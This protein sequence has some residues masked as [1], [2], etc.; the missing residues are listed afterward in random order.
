MSRVT[1]VA[2]LLFGS[3]ACSLVYETV[4]LREL[5]L[6]FGASTT[7]S[8][9][10]VAC[11]VGGLGAGGLIFGK[12]ADAHARPLALYARL[13][14]GIA[15]TAAVTPLLLVV[16]RAAYLGMGGTMTLGGF[17]GSVVR[18]LLA[19]M[20]FAVPTILMG[21]TLPAV[22]RAIESG[23]DSGRRDVAMLY[24]VNTL[25][26][27]TGCLASTFVLFEVLGTRLTLWCA[28]LVN[29]L[30]AVTANA[31]ARSMPARAADEG[32][33]DAAP[34]DAGPRP[35]PSPFVL[36]AAAIA[37]FVFCVMELVWYRM[38]GPLLGGT[39]FTFGLI[40]A[41]ALGGIGLGGVAYGA[42]P[43]SRAAT[44]LGFALTCLLEAAFVAI[45][46]A[47]G[48]RL[49]VLAAVLRPLGGLS[50][51]LQVTSW[52][53][54]TAI[55]VL[56]AAFVSGV[57]FPLLIGLLGRGDQAVGRDVGRA[58][59][60]NTLG[61]IAG[62]LAGGFG[63]MPA[64]SAPGCWRLVVWM[65]LLLGGAA[66][67][68]DVRR[69]P[70]AAVAPILAGVAALLCLR[71]QGPTA[72]W[73]HSPIGAGRVD[74]SE[75]RT[76]NDV[77]AW[78]NRR[79]RAIEWE[80][81]GRESSVA[82]SDEVG[83]AFIINGK[84]DG[85]VRTDASTAVMAGMVGAMLHPNP[86]SAMV[87]GLGTGE[88]AG[89]LAAIDSVERVDV[90]ELEP[91]VREVARRSAAGNHGALDNAKV[92]ITIGDARELL[93]TSKG[94]YDLIASEPSNPYR[95]GIAS[96]FTQSY[97]EAAR[98]RLQDGGLFLQWLQGYEVEAQTVRTVYATLASVFPEVETWEL[99]GGDM[100][101]VASGRP[102]E[103]D[104]ARMRARLAREPYKS[105]LALTWRAIDVEGF[106]SHFVAASALARQVADAE[107]EGINTDDRNIVEFGF[108]RSV[109]SGL[110]HFALSEVRRAARIRAEH[111]P[112]LADGAV[113]WERVDDGVGSFYLS[114]SLDPIEVGEP[115]PERQHRM[116]ALRDWIAGDSRRAVSEWR[117][118]PREAIDPT[119]LVVVASALADTGDEGALAYCDS[120]RAWEPGEAD[121]I[122]ASFRLRQGRLD[123]AASAFESF[124]T[125]LRTNPWPLPRL[126]ATALGRARAFA[127]HF[128]NFTPRLYAALREPFALHVLDDLRRD[129]ALSMAVRMGGPACV[130]EISA[131]EPNVIWTDAFLRSRYDCYAALHAP[132]LARAQSDLSAWILQS[133]MPFALGLSEP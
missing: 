83:L 114:E 115:T 19:A 58:Y 10:V 72:A 133:P 22:A 42:R 64:L 45:P 78:E 16:V 35:V 44:T 108:A 89:W 24:G 82:I 126:V 129:V 27:V 110:A 80:Q 23:G 49:A 50:F 57:Q 55:V 36:A 118:Q 15:A 70:R 39:V 90:A 2:L 60:M 103:H 47:L 128:P 38:L 18:L 53:V 116:A 107:G 7:A 66:T 100:L 43:R 132:G 123:D 25:G 59:A 71:A 5:R 75:L 74:A 102:V 51:V 32:A 11:F 46:Y 48:N 109:G 86:T 41:V 99:G 13:E 101:L 98:G 4:W 21:G 17:L 112:L 76:P 73:R 106:L 84:N 28:C 124:F 96:L 120:L 94:R 3:G 117:A 63:L 119:E 121:A 14:A 54:V 9:A 33:S 127:D 68:F 97:Y 56:P 6:V 95:A 92:R 105:A 104:V 40:L 12:R 29:A 91:A 111:R 130:E 34:L 87:I 52:A 81:E 62:S 37:G 69:R 88:S 79:R 26:A 93:L 122:V 65:L 31:I 77:Q 20:V 113:D 1:K 131:Y 30:V 67:A 8:A 61:A 85:N 125:G